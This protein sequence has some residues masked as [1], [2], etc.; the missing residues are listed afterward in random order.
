MKRSIIVRQAAAGEVHF[1]DEDLPL[2]VGS[3]AD[4]QIRLSSADDEAAHIGVSGGHLFIQPVAGCDLPLFHNNR[5]FTSSVWLK[6]GDEIRSSRHSVKYE[7][8]GDYLIFT[9]TAIESGAAAGVLTPPQELPEKKVRNDDISSELPVEVETGRGS[10]GTGF[11]TALIGG[12]FLLTLLAVLFVVLAQPLVVE[13]TPQPD[14]VSISGFPPC[15]KIASRRLCLQGTYGVTVQ[16]DGYQSFAGTVTV[17]ESTDNFFPVVLEKLPGILSLSVIPNGTV[18]VYSDDQLIGKT[19]P[20]KIEIAP[21]HHILKITR[22]RYQPFLTEIDIIGEGVAQEID[23]SL[24]PDWAA[25]TFNSVPQGAALLLDG[26]K[27]G[28]TPLSLDLLSGD[29]QVAMIKELFSE[30]SFDITVKAGQPETYGVTLH[31]L[32]G[33]LAVTSTH[34]KSAV[35]VDQKYRGITPVTVTLSSGDEHKIVLSA[36]G[37]GS[38]SKTFVL[39]PGEE[40]KLHMSLEQERGTV[41]LT[42]NPPGAQLTIDG[43]SYAAVGKLRLSTQPHRVEVSAPGYISETRSILPRI[44]FSQQIFIDLRAEG[45]SG[46]GAERGSSLPEKIIKTPGGQDLLYVQPASFTMGASRREAGR[47]AN[48]GK[49]TVTMKRDYYL[50]EKPVTNRQYREFDSKHTSGTVAGQ[51]LDGDQQPVVNISWEE[52]VKYLNWLSLKDNLLPFYI[53]KGN[54]FV[55]AEP[56]NNGYRLPSEAEWSFSARML[57]AE[58]IRRY[59]WDG[60]FPPRT[61]SGNYGDESARSFLPVIINGYR[62]SFAV[63]SPVGSFPANPGGFFDMGGNVG[64]W[65]HDY[66]SAYAGSSFRSSPDPLGPSAGTHRVIRGSSWRD[67]SITELRLSYRT[68]RRTARDNVGFRVARYR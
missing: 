8:K 43:K 39:K 37:Y 67:A 49:R 16:K 5:Y 30:T 35:S 26:K 45:S 36:P 14:T 21:G 57:G 17:A 22:K 53:K 34:E 13:V 55:P 51:T 9:V 61:V 18:S 27:Y 32:P 25:I 6:S 33:Y 59:P 58:K 42:A 52:A 15:V 1:T 28:Q 46:A 11:V 7:M 66:Y 31:L 63:S 65:C 50:A 19:P 60:G 56:L 10:S 47:R 64:E 68:Y 62:D 41:Y 3:G 48:E 20:G 12:I 44:G 54:S 24:Q 40:R 2:A 4:A 29:H 23:V 38:G